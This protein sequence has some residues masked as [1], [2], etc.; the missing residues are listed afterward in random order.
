[1]NLHKE[2]N[3]KVES[4]GQSGESVWRSS[5]GISLGR[6][7][8]ARGLAGDSVIDSQLQA[9]LFDFHRQIGVVATIKGRVL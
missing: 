5:H 6:S 8:G 4:Q 2:I 3:L 9:A 7:L 1:M